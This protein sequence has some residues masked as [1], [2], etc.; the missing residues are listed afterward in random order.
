MSIVL[1]TLMLR[2]KVGPSSQLE[3]GPRLIVPVSGNVNIAGFA[4]VVVTST[5]TA[6][7]AV[8]ATGWTTWGTNVSQANFHMIILDRS[9]TGTV[10]AV[11][12][13]AAD[14]RTIVSHLEYPGTT[15]VSAL[16]GAVTSSST[17]SEAGPY[18]TASTATKEAVIAIGM[19]NEI[20]STAASFEPPGTPTGYTSCLASPASNLNPGTQR[21]SFRVYTGA[22]VSTG[23]VT[24]AANGAGTKQYCLILRSVKL[25]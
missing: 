15:I 23:L 12:A 6:S 21:V 8:T 14:G 18:T 9:G 16:N 4:F 5:S 24:Q 11:T 25:V 1:N 3:D 22:S 10:P 17:G 7:P 19:T 2:R 13:T 20:V